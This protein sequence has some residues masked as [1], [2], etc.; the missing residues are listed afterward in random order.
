KPMTLHS[1]PLLPMRNSFLAIVLIT[2]MGLLSACGGGSGSGNA[3]DPPPAAL[4]ISTSSLPAGQTGVAYNAVLAATGGTP[5]YMWTLAS[6]TFPAG[7]ML[8][9][10]TGAIT[11]T[12]TQ[13]VTS[14]AL[15]FQVADSSTPPASRSVKMTLTI[16]SS[17]AGITVSPKSAGLTVTQTL[18]V[19]GTVANDTS[20]KAVSWSATGGSF[21]S[22]AS[23]SGASVTYTAP[24]TPG[25]YTITATQTSDVTQRA[26]STIGV[27]D[28]PGVYTYHNDSSR[29]GAN[30][31][32][33]ALTTA[34]VNSSTFGKLFSCQADAAIY[35]QPLWVSN[36]TIGG[37]K[38]NIVVVA[39]MHD[40]VYAFDADANPCV[41]YW[42][43]QFVPSGDT[44]FTAADV[45]TN[46]IFPDI[47]ILGTP[48]I[49]S[50][51]N[52]LYF[53][54]KTKINGP[55]IVAHQ[56][57]HALN[58]ADGTEVANSPVELDNSIT[59]PGN[60]EGGSTIGFNATTENQR[61]GLALVNGV[62][63]IA[64]ASHGDH[65]PYHGWIV[66][67][68]ATSLSR[69][70]AF[71]TSPNAAEGLGYCRAGIWMSG[72]APSADAAGNLYV[73]TGNG[74]F[75]GTSAFGDSFL[76]LSATSGLTLADW[77]TPMGQLSLDAFD[78]DLGAGGAAVLVDQTSGPH[79]HLIIGGGK[80]QVL[81]LL[82][83]TNMG[84]FTSGG[85]D[86]VVQ[87]LNVSEADFSTP[88]FW[89]NT[90]YFFGFNGPGLAYT[91]LPASDTFN[92]SVASATTASFSFPG[93]S[94]S[95]SSNGNSNGI[96]WMIDAHTSG[97]GDNG[98][99]SAG[100]AVL[101]AFDATNLG[102]E[103]WN[104]SQVPADAAGNAV[105]FTVPTVA[106]GKVY[107]GTRGN[108]TT[109]G[110]GTIFGEVDV[111]GLKPN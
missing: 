111:Y 20:Q 60:C 16:S 64:W 76:K 89:Q 3:A 67:F 100:P 25:I 33:Y 83:R 19:S 39:T 82:D 6:G 80:S 81:Y 44:L 95:V 14:T 48:V 87:T 70:S 21:S 46:S 32:E 51:S 36:I 79:P 38:H 30:T 24:S 1:R 47:G 53:V 34:N 98:P 66:G 85:P 84:H 8:N 96:V 109:L 41:T 56:R 42:H 77:F 15:T 54:T 11:G 102:T 88:A 45:F 90:L 13:A 93:S 68:N 29:D 18:S 107:V 23:A 105:K 2:A 50:T 69:V 12:P 78:Q 4:T 71:N 61:P 74:V 52:T 9:A 37:A 91:F 108:D 31:S 110:A 10:A 103:L 101:H 49:D 27:T 5:P 62:V 59:V 22:N 40:T 28:L 97:T 7:L 94:P 92:P 26:V 104:S 72:G 35:T 55:G 63:Y 17:S 58:L 43:T 86:K 99:A 106:N 57:L 73:I 75:D 65:D